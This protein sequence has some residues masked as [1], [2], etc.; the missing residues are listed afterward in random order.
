M[1]DMDRNE[2]RYIEYEYMQADVEHDKFSMLMDNYKCFGWNVDD[3]FNNVETN[4][5]ITIHLKRSRKI[6]NHTELTRLQHNFEDCL[7]KIK[8]LENSIKSKATIASLISGIVGTVFMAGSVFAVTA[9][10]PMIFLC[11][12]L[13]IPG[14]SGWFGAYFLYKITYKKR[15]KIVKPLIEDKMNEIYEICNKGIKLIE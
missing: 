12:I 11:I 2:G 3:N 8:Q 10:I 13:A 14:F 5:K 6:V 1:S 15:E 4:G 7:E 9:Q